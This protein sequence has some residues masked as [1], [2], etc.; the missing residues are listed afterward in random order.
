MQASHRNVGILL[1]SASILWK[2]REEGLPPSLI[3][4]SLPG[5][6]TEKVTSRNEGFTSITKSLGHLCFSVEMIVLRISD[7]VSTKLVAPDFQSSQK[8]AQSYSLPRWFRACKGISGGKCWPFFP[9]WRLTTALKEERKCWWPQLPMY[10]R[11][12]WLER[13]S[14][15]RCGIEGLWTPLLGAN[16]K[17]VVSVHLSQSW[18]LFWFF[19]L[20]LRNFSSC[21]EGCRLISMNS[22]CTELTVSNGREKTSFYLILKCMFSDSWLLDK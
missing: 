1:F 3:F 17:F 7:S 16:K 20:Y 14:C 18:I 22:V 5:R 8:A 4:C 12:N 2:S 15:R 11:T 21:T 13:C 19:F 9:L 6:I 10:R